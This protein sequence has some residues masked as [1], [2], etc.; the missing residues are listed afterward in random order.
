MFYVASALLTRK[1]RSFRKHSA[2]QAAFGEHFA[3]TGELD[4]KYHRG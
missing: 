1:G 3:R 2:V 4:P